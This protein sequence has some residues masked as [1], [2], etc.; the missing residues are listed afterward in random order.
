MAPIKKN[1]KTNLNG[2]HSRFYNPETSG[3]IWAPTEITG[4]F[5]PNFFGECRS[6]L[7]QPAPS[8]VFFSNPGDSAAS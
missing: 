1:K 7:I 8:C 3:V 4:D 6:V 5:G 2:F